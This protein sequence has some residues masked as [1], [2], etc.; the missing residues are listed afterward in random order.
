VRR[1]VLQAEET[2]PA[3]STAGQ[4]EEDPSWELMALCETLADLNFVL[5]RLTV[6][7][8]LLPLTPET[9]EGVLSAVCEQTRH[10][11][12]PVRVQSCV[13]RQFRASPTLPGSRVPKDYRPIADRS[14]WRLKT[15]AQ[16]R[17]KLV[18]VQGIF[19][20]LFCGALRPTAGV[21]RSGGDE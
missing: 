5:D 17:E 2:A 18:R 4:V 19:N 10:A 12:P 15:H 8:L 11:H 14:K 20:T 7:V 3:R 13:P 6:D 1:V 9:G 16:A 21:S